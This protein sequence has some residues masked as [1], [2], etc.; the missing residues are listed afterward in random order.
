M[1][2]SE[3]MSERAGLPVRLAMS[4]T[5]RFIPEGTTV[6]RALE[7][8]GSFGIH[9]LPIGSAEACTGL[10]CTCDLRNA[11]LDA[12]VATLTRGEVA[13]IAPEATVA[14]AES[15]MKELM[16]G[17][18]LVSDQRCVVGIVTRGDLLQ[19]DPDGPLADVYCVCCGGTEHLTRDEYQQLL[20]VDCHERAT[21]PREYDSGGG[22]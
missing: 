3:R 16:I 19:W 9:H 13:R 22:D 7:L 1:A 10:L 6:R 14:A 21:E 20:C 2:T 12:D 17:S 15:S 11:A 18:L 4:S 5:V 8:A